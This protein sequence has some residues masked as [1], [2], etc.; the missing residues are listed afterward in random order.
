M[1]KVS[2]SPIYTPLRFDNDDFINW[3]DSET[4]RKDLFNRNSMCL[5]KMASLDNFSKPDC[6]MKVSI[7]QKQGIQRYDRILFKILLIIIL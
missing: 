2:Q 7:D 4:I 5:P 6:K 1:N 3:L